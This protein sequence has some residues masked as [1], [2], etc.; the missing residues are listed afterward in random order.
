MDL[1]ANREIVAQ[2]TNTSLRER[3]K[4]NM[5][6][7]WLQM[8]FLVLGISEPLGNG[9]TDSPHSGLVVTEALAHLQEQALEDSVLHTARGS[10]GPNESST[11]SGGS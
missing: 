8:E 10:I 3:I 2:G 4:E 5:A 9:L 7:L 11:L 6:Y 1:D